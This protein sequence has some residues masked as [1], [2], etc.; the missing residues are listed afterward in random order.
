MYH[1]SIVTDLSESFS[2]TSATA[3]FTSG[4]RWNRKLHVRFDEDPLFQL[5]RDVLLSDKD[6][7]VEDSQ[8]SHTGFVSKTCVWPSA[9]AVTFIRCGSNE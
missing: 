1:S 6:T 8:V 9:D 3:L 7:G 4:S 5:T 2:S